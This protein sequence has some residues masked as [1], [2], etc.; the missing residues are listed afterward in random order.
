MIIII[1]I[2]GHSQTSIVVQICSGR[3]AVPL[4]N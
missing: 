4:R 3:D 1:I 2:I